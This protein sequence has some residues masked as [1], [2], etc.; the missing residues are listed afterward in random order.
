MEPSWLPTAPA[1]GEWETFR[2]IRLTENLVALKSINGHFVCAE[3]G[4]GREVVA[5]RTAIGPWETFQWV[6]LAHGGSARERIALKASNG[7]FVCAEGGG[8]GCVN[9]NRNEAK[10]GR[11]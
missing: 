9:A 11:P 1:V 5:N 8:G 2:I 10:T 7:Q 4:G 3:N 6:T